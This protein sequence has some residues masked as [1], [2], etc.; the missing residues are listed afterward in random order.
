MIAEITASH[1]SGLTFLPPKTL[2]TNNV[3]IDQTRVTTNQNGKLVSVAW[4]VSP[5][6]GISDEIWLSQSFSNGNT[7]SQA[8]NVSNSPETSSPSNSP[9]LSMNTLGIISIAWVEGFTGDIFQR[10]ILGGVLTAITNISQTTEGS[11]EPQVDIDNNGNSY[12]IWQE[13][14]NPSE[15][16]FS[17]ISP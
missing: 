16:L 14:L 2:P 10:Q 15:I 13:E 5:E 12:I 1:N 6:F 11:L 3:D 8:I 4:R 9:S 17:K 7:F